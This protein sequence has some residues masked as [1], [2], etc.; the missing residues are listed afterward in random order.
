MAA[1]R[2]ALRWAHLPLLLLL[3]I[4]L[5]FGLWTFRDYGLSWDEPLF[6]AYGDAIG[7]AY[8]IREHLSGEFDLGRA[9]GPSGDDHKTRGPAYLVLTRSLVYAIEDLTGLER[10]EAWHLVNFLTFQAGIALLYFL[11]LRLIGHNRRWI[12]AMGAAFFSW[13]PLLWGHAFINP[14]DPSFLVFFSAAFLSGLRMVD[15]IRQPKSRPLGWVLL[16]GTLLGAATAIRILAPLAGALTA[17][18]ALLPPRQDDHLSA[19]G[20]RRFD[21]R[22]LWWLIPYGLTALLSMLALWPYLWEEPFQRFVEVFRFMSANPTQLQVLFGGETYRAYDLPRRYLPMYLLITL[23]EPVWPLF[24]IGLVVTAR[25]VGK[26]ALNGITPALLLLWFAIPFAYVL[27]KRPPMYDGFRH[28]LFIVPPVF[29]FAAAGM[30]ALDL[31]LSTL[32]AKFSRAARIGLGLMLLLPAYLAIPKLHP[33]E[34]AYYNSLVGGTGG[35]FRQY[36]TDYWLTCY[37]E[38]MQELN[39]MAPNARLIVHREAYIAAA[40]AAPGMTVLDYRDKGVALQPG[41]YFLVSCR[42][43]EDLRLQRDLPVIFTVGR[44]GAKFCT[45]KQVR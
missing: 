9:Y 24:F 16:A 34:Y 40:Y 18:Y 12:A 17:L 6:Y 7:Y 42:L 21:I 27:L 11:I 39:R 23:T 20:H 10:S 25:R 28:F 33:Y 41:N 45:V 2:H 30:D 31:A 29:V 26:K 37:K 36:E 32:P 13:Q 44:D 1:P 8:S 35:A 15:E 19:P 4:N 43:N 22:A 5:A 14:K 38:A 3:V